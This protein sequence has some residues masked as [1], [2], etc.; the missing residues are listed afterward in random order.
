MTAACR[1]LLLADVPRHDGSISAAPSATYQISVLLADT[2]EEIAA[3]QEAILPLI[4][5]HGPPRREMPA[6]FN[7]RRAFSLARTL[8]RYFRRRDSTPHVSMS[9]K[10]R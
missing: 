4:L 7:V 5:R 8:R 6:I 10:P 1:K 9:A 3:W 2:A